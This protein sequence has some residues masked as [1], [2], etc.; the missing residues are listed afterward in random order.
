MCSLI[1]ST[2]VHLDL[3]PSRGGAQQGHKGG[4]LLLPEA[5]GRPSRHQGRR[6]PEPWRPPAPRSR[7]LLGLCEAPRRCQAV[8]GAFLLGRG[9]LTWGSEP[10]SL[11]STVQTHRPSAISAFICKYCPSDSEQWQIVT[12]LVTKAVEESVAKNKLWDTQLLGCTEL[13][14][15]TWICN[16]MFLFIRC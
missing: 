6:I 9:V 5:G 2:S 1:P 10:L 13:Q 3:Y 16:L 12:L 4:E 11:E 8:V 7:T 14:F 15:L